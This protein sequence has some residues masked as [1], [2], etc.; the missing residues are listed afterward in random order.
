MYE[1]FD[2]QEMELKLLYA[3]NAI[4]KMICQFHHASTID[5]S[6]DLY[7]SNYC[8]SALEAA[9]ETLGIEENYIPLWDFCVMYES[10]NRAIWEHNLPDEPYEGITADIYYECI[11][12][13]YDSWQRTLEEIANEDS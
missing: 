1:E 3:K 5:N 8:E 2:K 12:E 6:G 10:N 4:F 9:F 13:E 7:I 11:K